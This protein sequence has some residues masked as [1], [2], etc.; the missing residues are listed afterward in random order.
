MKRTLTLLLILVSW[1]CSKKNSTTPTCDIT[2]ITT[3]GSLPAES[4]AITYNNTGKISTLVDTKTTA[5][6]TKV[7]TYSGNT[8]LVHTTNTGT[9][10]VQTDSITLN[11]DGLMVSDLTREGT[12]VTLATYTYSGTSVQSVTTQ[13]GTDPPT[14]VSYTYTNGDITSAGGIT[15]TYN[16]KP[17]SA[18]DFLQFQQLD[19]YGVVFMKTAHQCISLQEG[20]TLENFNYTYD[21]SG[22]ITQMTATLGSNFGSFNYTYECD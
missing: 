13:F 5:T 17:S 7:Y 21:P 2:D 4:I 10:N 15:Y 1:S 18:G 16:D 19:L 12:N 9:T 6:T 3:S 8:V 11:G 14:T 20:N 22:K